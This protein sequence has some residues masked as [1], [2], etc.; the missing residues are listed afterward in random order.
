MELYGKI[1]ALSSL[2]AVAQEVAD[3]LDPADLAQRVTELAVK[4]IDSS[5]ADIVRVTAS[6]ALRV[7]VSSDPGLS[8]LTARVW[9]NWPLGAGAREA[10]PSASDG[11][12]AGYLAELRAETGVVDE[13]VWPLRVAEGNHGH[14]RFLFTA[15]SSPPPAGRELAAAFAAHAALALDRSALLVQVANLRLAVV[16]NREIGA[17]VGILMARHRDSYPTAFSSLCK[18]S[19]Q[20]NRKLRDVAAD[21]LHT[22]DLP[23]GPTAA[24]R[25]SRAG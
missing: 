20:E 24:A 17:A 18:I 7:L 9:A 12:R 8:E 10:F 1:G 11:R 14:L 2:S 15:T 3:P 13:W 16:S 19:Q 6:G 4:L 25:S 5:A 22:G 23:D 21:V